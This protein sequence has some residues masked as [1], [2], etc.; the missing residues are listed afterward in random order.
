MAADGISEVKT[1][2]DLSGVLSSGSSH[3]GTLS[4]KPVT[5]V[6]GGPEKVLSGRYFLNKDCFTSAVSPCDERELA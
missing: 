2:L 6:L 1:L 4:L 5:N 3:R